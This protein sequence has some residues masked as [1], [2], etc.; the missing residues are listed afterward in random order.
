MENANE[1]ITKTQCGHLIISPSRSLRTHL[2]CSF[3]AE[4][5]IKHR[6][7]WCIRA[8]YSDWI[9]LNLIYSSFQQLKRSATYTDELTARLVLLYIHIYIFV[10]LT[11]THFG[12]YSLRAILCSI[13]SRSACIRHT[14]Y[15]TNVCHHITY[16]QMKC[17]HF[18]RRRCLLLCEPAI[19]SF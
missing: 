12:K 4:T 10:L 17:G 11:S 3:W 15:L 9:K 7:M 2:L 16:D 6:Y 18:Y 8:F 1:T 5:P 14:D 13:Y 19:Y